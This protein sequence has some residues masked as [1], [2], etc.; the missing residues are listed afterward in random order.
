MKHFIFCCSIS[1]I[2][3]VSYGQ[4]SICSNNFKEDFEGYSNGSLFVSQV[5]QIGNTCWTTWDCINGSNNVQ[6]VK[7]LNNSSSGNYINIYA[8]NSNGGPDD[9][10]RYL[11]NKTSGR[12]ELTFDIRVRPGKC[13]LYSM[14]HNFICN[15]P[16]NS[17]YAFTTRFYNGYIQVQLGQSNYYTNLTNYSSNTWIGVKHIIDLDT[18]TIY[19]YPNTKYGYYYTWSFDASNRINRN[20]TLG[21]IDFWAHSNSDY[22]IDNIQLTS[23]SNQSETFNVFPNTVLLKDGC[24]PSTFCFNITSNTNWSINAPA[25]LNLSPVSGSGNS[26]ICGSTSSNPSASNR[27]ATINFSYGINNNQGSP[28]VVT[29]EGCGQPKYCYFDPPS[30]S[31][32]CNGGILNANLLSN[33][34]WNYSSKPNWIQIKNSDL[35]GSGSK[36]IEITADQNNSISRSGIIKYS[37]G[38]TFVDLYV[39]QAACSQSISSNPSSISIDCKKQTFNA[40]ITSTANWQIQDKPS[41]VNDIQPASGFP[42]NTY[43]TIGSDANNATTSR[44]GIIKIS[45]GS[46]SSIYS[47][48]IF[49]DAC[50]VNNSCYVIPSLLNVGDF[51]STYTLDIYSNTFWSYVSGETNWLTVSP[52]SGSPTKVKIQVI[53]NPYPSPRSTRIVFT[54]GATGST[55]SLDIN[56]SANNCIFSISPNP[57]NVESYGVIDTPLTL[58]STSNWFLSYNDPDSEPSS[59]YFGGVSV[60]DKKGTLTIK[61]NTSFQPRLLKLTYSYCQNSKEYELIINQKGNKIIAN[62]PWVVNKTALTHTVIIDKNLQSDIFGNPLDLGDWIGFFYKDD[63]LSCAGEGQWLGGDLP[64]LVYGD[65]PITATQDGFKKS[66]T[67]IVKI[68]KYNTQNNISTKTEYYQPNGNPWT[69][70]DKFTDGGLSGIYF[71][72]AD[73]CIKLPVHFGNSLI[74]SYIKPLDPNMLN[75]FKQ[76]NTSIRTIVDDS[77]QVTLPWNNFNSIGNWNYK[78]AYKISASFESLISDAFCGDKIVPENEKI[79]IIANQVSFIPYLRDNIRSVDSEFSK[80]KDKI[81]WMKDEDLNTLLLPQ[82]NLVWGDLEPFKGYV[83]KARSSFDLIYSPNFKNNETQL[84]SNSDNYQYGDY[85]ET[86]FSLTTN[87]TILVIPEALAKLYF[88]LNDEIAVFNKLGQ[89]CGSSKYNGGNFVLKI[90]GDNPLTEKFDGLLVGEYLIFK[91]YNLLS[92]SIEEIQFS[93]IDN[94]VPA[95][96][97]NNMFIASEV[98]ENKKD[99]INVFP[100]PAN[101]LIYI[102]GLLNAKSLH[103]INNMGIKVRTIQNRDFKNVLEL[104]INALESGSYILQINLKDKN[105]IVY[106]KVLVFK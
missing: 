81:L 97:P 50:P 23:N 75:I 57:I 60:M 31:Y 47:I 100:N 11:G 14:L 9:I 66:Q 92:N 105:R 69:S 101:D 37:C 35:A 7:I 36:I 43:I 59:N 24:N 33:D 32:L 22:D 38:S 18:K 4:G 8:L 12:Y 54:C 34:S 15:D 28:L 55:F 79:S 102:T 90:W 52:K 71:I 85:F 10:V 41:W 26:L 62:P 21:A 19:F 80:Y 48:P 51:D 6:D 68:R 46:P 106:K 82:A 17:D 44:S 74:S 94:I 13:A 93:F 73:N 53:A 77:G 30:L 42:P 70:S 84:R 64:I 98:L 89:V 103:L 91:K 83:I 45:Y 76:S 25:W 3:N 99:L 104:D 58:N 40:L 20:N 67:F 27:S 29:Q 88:N 63:T 78:K 61:P 95:F 1:L 16:N 39:S 56:Q 65:D 72:K 87:G 96:D 5:R 2:I 86:D 49:Q